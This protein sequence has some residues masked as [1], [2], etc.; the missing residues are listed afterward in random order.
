MPA[1]WTGDAGS[2]GDGVSSLTGGDATAFEAIEGGTDGGTTPTGAAV[3]GGA[4]EAGRAVGSGEG[5]A[6]LEPPGASVG[7]RGVVDGN[8]LAGGATYRVAGG[9]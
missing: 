7:G 4:V 6:W 3:A 8:T 1:T 2:T 9:K 5:A